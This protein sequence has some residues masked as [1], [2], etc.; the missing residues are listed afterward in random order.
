MVPVTG[1]HNEDLLKHVTEFYKN[2]FGSVENTGVGL[3]GDIWNTNE[4]LN[5][6]DRENM[7]MRFTEEEAKKV[8][9]QMEKNKAAGPNAIPIKF[10]QE[11]WDIIKMI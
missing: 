7:S 2:L 8:I 11:C 6:T 10:Y 9:Y 1:R 5:D 4:K 3:N